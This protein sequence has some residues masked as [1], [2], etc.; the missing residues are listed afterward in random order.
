M[1]GA[2]SGGDMTFGQYIRGWIGVVAR[3]VDIEGVW[4]ALHI[5]RVAIVG[6]LLQAWC[7]RGVEDLGMVLIL[8]G[9]PRH[10]PDTR[11]V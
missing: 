3:P 11:G 1:H 5:A 10:C 7:R 6:C 4:E 9:L 8:L 2:G